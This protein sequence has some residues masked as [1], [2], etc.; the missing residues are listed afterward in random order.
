[1]REAGSGGFVAAGFTIGAAHYKDI[2]CADY[3]CVPAREDGRTS[4]QS[5][6]GR[7]TRG[8]RGCPTIPFEPHYTEI[9]AG[10]RACRCASI[11]IDGE[12]DPNAPLVLLSARP[13]EL[14]LPVPQDG[15][16][17]GGIG[18]T[19]DCAR[20]ARLRQ[21]RQTGRTRRLQLSTAG[22]LD[23]AMARGQ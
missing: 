10:D 3:M 15:A 18:I 19:G 23:G 9:D 1:M 11:I 17:T 4:M 5:T 21:V 2:V 6:Y 12:G 8:L 7:R 14:E 22:R 16:P 20:S 13:A